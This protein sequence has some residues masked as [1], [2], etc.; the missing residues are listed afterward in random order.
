MILGAEIALVI[1]G[2]YALVKGKLTLT[3]TRVVYGT[4][5][6]LLAII[7]FLPMP[8][9][10]VVG[11]IFGIILAASGRDATAT[12]VRLTMV[13][14]EVG[15]LV[16]CVAALYGLGWQLAKPPEAGKVDGEI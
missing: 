12:S 16:L 3:K 5:A 11:V 4:H 2:I 10:L 14:I 8:L 13:G 7:A 6:R 9:S 15:V 1:L